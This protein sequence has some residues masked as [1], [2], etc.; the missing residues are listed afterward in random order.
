EKYGQTANHTQDALRILTQATHSP[1]K[2]LELLGTA[3]DL[4]A[5]KHE[6]LDEA[7]SQLGKVYN[8][9]KKLLK[10]FGVQLD[11]STGKTK[12]GQSATRAL[13]GVLAGKAAASAD[14]FTGKLKGITATV[15]DQAAMFGQ[16]YGPAITAA[17][18]AVTVLGGV[19]STT[20]ALARTFAAS[21]AA[22]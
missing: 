11:A 14:T 19:V 3:T 20:S 5:A 2:A 18:A 10:E 17:G 8:G 15:E 21:Q 4:A 9:N 13:A 7:A 1:A 22:V 16:K 12:D 6:S